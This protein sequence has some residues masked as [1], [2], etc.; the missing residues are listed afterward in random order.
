MM[1]PGCED[2]KN[3]NGV[4]KL[5]L[6]LLEQPNP[7]Y[8]IESIVLKT[9]QF[10][11]EAALFHH[12]NSEVLSRIIYMLSR[13]MTRDT[14]NNLSAKWMSANGMKPVLEIMLKCPGIDP[15][16]IIFL[17]SRMESVRPSVKYEDPINFDARS[18]SSEPQGG[19]MGQWVMRP[20][21]FPYSCDAQSGSYKPQG[22]MRERGR[23]PG[24]YSFDAQSESYELPKLSSSGSSSFSS[25]RRNSY[26]PLH[27]GSQSNSFTFFFL[28]FLG[29]I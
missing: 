26:S 13:V 8:I 21:G 18:D 14:E 2:P 11:R 28:I 17:Q 19:I 9:F 1:R 12:Y 3:I 6:S 4:C 5:V 7:K 22:G 10:I 25:E 29:Q 27:Y 23:R 15:R 20:G 24:A 16:S